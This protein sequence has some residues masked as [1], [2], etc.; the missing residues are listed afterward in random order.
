MQNSAKTIYNI[1]AGQW[2]N[3]CGGGVWWSTAHTYKNAV[4]NELFL[5]ISAQGFLRGFGQN[6]LDN[7]N[8]VGTLRDQSMRSLRSSSRFG[9]GVS[10]LM[11]P[12]LS[13][14]IVNRFLQSIPIWNEELARFI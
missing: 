2:D 4:T 6:Y 14:V 3:Q 11:R 1:I 10:V 13:H 8:K 5:Y 9:I 12:H 7:A